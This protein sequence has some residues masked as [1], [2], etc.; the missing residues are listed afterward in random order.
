MG[1]TWEANEVEH[2]FD[3]GNGRTMILRKSIPL[4]WLVLRAMESDDPALAAALSEWFETGKVVPDAGE[5][6]SKEDRLAMLAVASRVQRAILEEMFIRPRVHWDPATMP[7]DAPVAA[8]GEIP[9]HVS[10]GDLTDLEMTEALMMAFAGAEDAARFRRDRDG[11]NGGQGG[12][13]L[14]GDPVEPP[15]RKAGKR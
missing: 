11:A 8:P 4:Q 5:A 3:N 10:A 14:G 7:D 15:R 1:Q 12:A 13:V 2:T 6:A 9:Y